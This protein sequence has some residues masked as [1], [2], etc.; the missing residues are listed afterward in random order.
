MFKR[1]GAVAA[2]VT[3]FWGIA[4]PVLAKTFSLQTV[5]QG[6]SV[7]LVIILMSCVAF[8]FGPYK[9][10]VFIAL[11]LIMTAL[12]FIG[13]LVFLVVFDAFVIFVTTPKP[14]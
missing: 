7:A 3:L 6:V 9:R 12:S 2:F 13:L 1:Y 11:S 8:L 4:W 14:A 10:T 5:A